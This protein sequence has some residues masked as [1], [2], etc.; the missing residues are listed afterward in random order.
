[1]NQKPAKYV[2]PVMR[3]PR[4][5]KSCFVSKRTTNSDPKK[6]NIEMPIVMKRGCTC[7]LALDAFL[8]SLRY[9]K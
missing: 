1:M 4:V 8:K 5:R 6:E 3:Y 7:F 2:I 9:S